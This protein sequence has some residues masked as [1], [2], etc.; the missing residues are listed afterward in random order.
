MTCFNI[1]KLLHE[2]I[3]NELDQVQQNEIAAH[4]E[5]CSEC[6]ELWAELNGLKNL[7][8][9][10]RTPQPPES[11]W[12]ETTR[13]IMAKTV[14]LADEPTEVISI[15]EEESE[16]KTAF[17]RSLLSVAASIAL[18]LV[19]IGLNS[20]SLTTRF[21]QNESEPLVFTTVELNQKFDLKSHMT[22]EQLA[23]FA[24][25]DNSVSMGFPGIPGGLIQ[26]VTTGEIN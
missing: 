20:S 22:D 2:Y 1:Q 4:L 7:L 19:S 13:L 6:H 15:Y 23:K 14:D 24:L 26:S 9:Q 3:D 10:K 21:A 16:K 5:S 17:R 12:E 18:L 25:I 8:G 11:Y